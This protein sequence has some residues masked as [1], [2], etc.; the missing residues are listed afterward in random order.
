MDLPRIDLAATTNLRF[1]LFS[2]SIW[3]SPS[4]PWVIRTLQQ[5]KTSHLEYI[6][7]VIDIGILSMSDDFDR[8]QISDYKWQDLDAVL[9]G[10]QDTHQNL[11]E[12]VLAFRKEYSEDFDEDETVIRSLVTQQMLALHSAGCL[13][14][15]VSYLDAE[16]VFYIRKIT[17]VLRVLHKPVRHCKTTVRHETSK[18]SRLN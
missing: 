10:S 1:F 12:V 17:F 7:L 6:I 14:V 4:L 9:K 3:D 8:S 18:T 13:S 11:K 5:M 16:M 2:F 15:E